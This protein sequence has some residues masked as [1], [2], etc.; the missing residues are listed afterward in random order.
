MHC[1]IWILALA[2]VVAIISEYNRF[3]PLK[4]LFSLKLP[5]RENFFN[6]RKKKKKVKESVT[7]SLLFF[8][9]GKRL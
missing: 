6:V 3:A 7:N 9:F 4:L 2:Q 8:V 1:A 5:V